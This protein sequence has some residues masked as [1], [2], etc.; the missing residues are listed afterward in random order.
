MNTSND[1]SVVNVSAPN[2]VSP[3]RAVADHSNKAAA[4]QTIKPGALDIKEIRNIA[5]Q[6]RSRETILS[7]GEK[8]LAE[9]I[10][11]INKVISGV[12][13]EFQRSIH[14][15]ANTVVITMID[16]DT[17]DVILEIPPENILDAYV[18]RME[19][20]GLYVDERR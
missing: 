17:G 5:N 10:E 4:M 13:L 3:V 6:N 15:G 8:A 12:N 11:Y 19:L 14:E 7:V 18:A 2:N 1:V 16:K 20:L 9:A